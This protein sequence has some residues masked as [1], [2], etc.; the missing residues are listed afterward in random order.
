MNKG[1]Q[2]RRA[3]QRKLKEEKRKRWANG[4]SNKDYPVVRFNRSYTNYVIWGNT[5]T[6][7]QGRHTQYPGKRAKIR[8]S[9]EVHEDDGSYRN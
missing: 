7:Q 3:I 2:K 5:T 1:K 4:V 6:R 8:V 9:V